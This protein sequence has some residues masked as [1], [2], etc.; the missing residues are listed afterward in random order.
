MIQLKTSPEILDIS[1]LCLEMNVYRTNGYGTKI[2]SRE[3]RVFPTAEALKKFVEEHL[4][5][6]H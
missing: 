2:M 4:S 3:T 5:D 6:A 1:S